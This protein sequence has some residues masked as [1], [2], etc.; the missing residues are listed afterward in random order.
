MKKTTVAAL[1]VGL[2]LTSPITVPV[3]VGH[4]AQAAI[5][6]RGDDP[7]GGWQEPE[8]AAA[9]TRAHTVEDLH[10]QQIKQILVWVLILIGFAGFVLVVAKFEI[11]MRWLYQRFV[12]TAAV[13]VKT[14]RHARG[15]V[16]IVT[17]DIQ[18]KIDAG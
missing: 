8:Q 15:A 16:D 5:V 17:H 14:K 6:V 13:M 9:I 1:A 18:A 12:G 2:C 10:Q 7:E 3:I 11:I 4:G